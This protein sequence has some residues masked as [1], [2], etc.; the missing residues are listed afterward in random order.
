MNLDQIVIV[1]NDP[2]GNNEKYS[3]LVDGYD[4]PSHPCNIDFLT[5]YFGN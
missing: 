5:K 4:E 1:N 3:M 2:M